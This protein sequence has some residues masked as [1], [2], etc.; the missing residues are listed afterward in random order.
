[1]W[2]AK[3]IVRQQKEDSKE[4]SKRG[5]RK[6]RGGVGQPCLQSPIGTSDRAEVERTFE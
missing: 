2:D 3:S 1:M 4:E 6:E 5:M